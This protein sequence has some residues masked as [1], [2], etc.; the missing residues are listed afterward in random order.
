MKTLVFSKC[1]KSDQKTLYDLC[2]NPFIFVRQVKILLRKL[3]WFFS[4]KSIFTLKTWT[5]RFSV[6]LPE[7]FDWSCP[8]LRLQG[9]H[10]L[11][12]LL[13][14]DD[15]AAGTAGAA[16]QR[17]A[18]PEQG[19]GLSAPARVLGPLPAAGGTGDGADG[20]DARQRDHRSQVRASGCPSSFLSGG[21]SVWFR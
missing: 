8:Q 7:W 13:E 14:T 15:D 2:N 18:E 6:R 20:D 3:E 17:V 21:L 10:R 12:I 1:W 4:K 19:G 11:H 16:V 9:D 5:T